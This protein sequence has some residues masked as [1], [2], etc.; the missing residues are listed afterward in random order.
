MSYK[1]HFV[2]P[3]AN[4]DESIY[5]LDKILENNFKVLEINI[6]EYSQFHYI[7]RNSYERDLGRKL[8]LNNC[9]SKNLK[10]YYIHNSFELKNFDENHPFPS[11]EENDFDQ[12]MYLEYLDPII[13]LLR[14]FKEGNICIPFRDYYWEKDGIF[15]KLGS[16]STMN[17]TLRGGFV[18]NPNE[19]FEIKKFLK[20]TKIPFEEDSIEL[21]FQNYRLSYQVRNI[22]LQFLSIIN[23]LES[24]LHPGNEGELTYRIS[25]NL[26]VLIAENENDANDIFSK[27]KFLYSKRSRIVHNGKADIKN[28]DVLLARHYL[29]E[30]IKK[31]NKLYKYRDNYFKNDYNF[32]DSVFKLLTAK[33][34]GDQL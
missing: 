33:G 14:I 21:A 6:N 32:K 17:P 34:F 2:G 28:D 3:L 10:V 12:K 29:R 27:M 7:V 24:L 20:N 11:K 22:N 26:G 15:T 18:L 5:Y 19:I 16:I 23:G 8:S 31:F 4:V 30:C 25:R 13:E 1:L 9:H